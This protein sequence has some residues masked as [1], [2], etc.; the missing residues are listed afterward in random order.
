VNGCCGFD[1][2]ERVD[3][4]ISL[5]VTWQDGFQF[6][7]PA[8]TSW[9][10]AGRSF[11]MSLKGSENDTASLLSM[12]TT[13]GRILIT[14][15]VGRVIFFNVPP[16]DLATALVPGEYVYDLLMSSGSPPVLVPMFHG[17]VCVENGI[18]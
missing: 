13:N 10:L 12:T 5:N 7:D 14:D 3:F 6:G 15:A 1:P 8:D 11:E 4:A 2:S 17:T 9:D 18:T 16:A